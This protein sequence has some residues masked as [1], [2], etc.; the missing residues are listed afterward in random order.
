MNT[1]RMENLVPLVLMVFAEVGCVGPTYAPLT[2]QD[3]LTHAVVV[4]EVEPR[5]TV[6]GAEYFWVTAINGQP[7]LGF[8]ERRAERNAE[9]KVATFY[10]LLQAG[11]YDL[12]FSYAKVHMALA[13]AHAWT[14]DV[15]KRIDLKNGIIRCRGTVSG[16]FATLWL[17]DAAGN[18]LTEPEEA[19][20]KERPKPTPIP[21]I[22]PVHR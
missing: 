4:L 11:Q 1:M 15:T 21:I 8:Q 2:P 5:E 20:I 18:R 14:A 12:T 9:G 7:A 10:V 3:S 17:E 16:H 19:L 13:G 6:D 22:I